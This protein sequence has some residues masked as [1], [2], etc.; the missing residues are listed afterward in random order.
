MHGV[1]AAHHQSWVNSKLR[2]E[3]RSGRV[4]DHHVVWVHYPRGCALD[5]RGV[6]LLI[7]L[8]RSQT[9]GT[10]HIKE[11]NLGEVL[12]DARQ[13]DTSAAEVMMIIGLC[14]ICML[15]M[16]VEVHAEAV[17]GLIITKLK[18]SM[19]VNFVMVLTYLSRNRKSR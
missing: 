4:Y 8:R 3:H 2:G 14:E 5:F 18:V 11:C 12:P 9:C 13:I 6:V 17:V 10:L 16:Y 1:H 15:V 7:R 19:T